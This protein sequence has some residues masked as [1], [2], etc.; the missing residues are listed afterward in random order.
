M[1]KK[2]VLQL[3]LQLNFWV[4]LDTYN[5]LYI[6][7]NSLQLNY[8][9]VAKTPFQL[10]CNSSMTI[11]IMSR[12]CQFS[13]I[14]QNLT[15]GTMR[16]FRDVLKYWYLSFIMIICFKRSWIMTRGTIKKIATWHINWILETYIYLFIYLFVC[17]CV[18]VCVPM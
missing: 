2:G 10:L 5:S 3:D 17:V 18:C 16:I 6:W 15:R 11:I 8:N 14:H 12:W 9:F 1:R 4:A 13:S 7:C